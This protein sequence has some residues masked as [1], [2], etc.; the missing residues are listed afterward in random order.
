MPEWKTS[1]AKAHKSKLAKYWKSLIQERS[2]DAHENAA[3][4]GYTQ[5]VCRSN[6]RKRLRESDNNNKSSKKLKTQDHKD[7]DDRAQIATNITDTLL[8]EIKRNVLH[9]ISKASE[10]SN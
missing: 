8:H 1:N 9:K 10:N 4:D 3:V 2:I 5:E 7:D 6:G